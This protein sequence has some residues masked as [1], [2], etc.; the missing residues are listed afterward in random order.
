MSAGKGEDP[1]LRSLVFDQIA[2]IQERSGA[3]KYA[4]LSFGGSGSTVTSVGLLVVT[5]RIPIA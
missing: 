5:I 1:P 2:G 3:Y 4:S